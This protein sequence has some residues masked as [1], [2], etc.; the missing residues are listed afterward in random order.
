MSRDIDRAVA[1]ALGYTDIRYPGEQDGILVG[2]RDGNLY[3]VPF[4]STAIDDAWQLI[5]HVVARG[6]DYELSNDG[7]TVTCVLIDEPYRS[8]TG[9]GATPEEAICRAFL[10]AVGQGG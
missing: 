7:S 5:D 10:A 6:W 2:T 9:T 1:R 3:L 8:V 4:Y